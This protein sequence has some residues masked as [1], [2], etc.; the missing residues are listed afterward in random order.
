MKTEQQE[1]LD[2]V[3]RLE[4]LGEDVAWSIT[5]IANETHALLPWGCGYGV[6]INLPGRDCAIFEK[7]RTLTQAVDRALTRARAAVSKV[8]P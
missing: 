5:K 6:T 8:Q 3:E 7:A 1:F 2:A 4:A